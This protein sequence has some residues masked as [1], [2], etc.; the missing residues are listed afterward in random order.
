[1]GGR[2]RSKQVRGGRSRPTAPSALV[3][4]PFVSFDVHAVA[5]MALRQE[6]QGTAGL[7]PKAISPWPVPSRDGLKNPTA[8]PRCLD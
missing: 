7:G 8:H 6:S 5:T 3:P 4:R 1:M 2:T